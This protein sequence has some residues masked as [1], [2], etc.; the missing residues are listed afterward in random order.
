MFLSG[1][2]FVFIFY[3]VLSFS[4]SENAVLDGTLLKVLFSRRKRTLT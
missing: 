4:V 2:S 3:Q 1:G